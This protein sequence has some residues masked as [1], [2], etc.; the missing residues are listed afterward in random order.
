MVGGI[1]WAFLTPHTSTCRALDSFGEFLSEIGRIPLL[2]PA[3]E[4]HLGTICQAWQQHPDGPADCP[5][6][7]RRRGL[8]A[9]ERMT[10]ANLRLV[11]CIAR[12][13][14]RLAE[15]RGFTLAD[16]CQ[17]GA[18]GLARGVEKF[19]PAKGYKLSTYA[20]W[21]IRQGIGRALETGGLI[22]LP[23]GLR[24][25]AAK[26]AEALRDL[27]PEATPEAVAA[28]VGEP[29]SRCALAMAAREVARLTSL[30][31]KARSDNDDGSSVIE[32]LADP[33]NR[34]CTD[35]L[36]LAEAV[37]RLGV[38]PGDLDLMEESLTSTV[39][40][41]AKAQGVTRTTMSAR[42][43]AARSRL[44]TIAGPDARALLLEAA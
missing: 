14:T 42:L 34:P 40:A 27:G 21:W 36:E 1:A 32:L 12:R 23:T 16:L 31:G 7:I 38:L 11:V 39:T 20:Y 17:E 6:D 41:L 9:R 25:I 24:R 22:R 28:V 13:S 5:A 30:D 35:S 37:A 8:R 10:K 43:K 33:S 18:I 2:T 15:D 3:E 19:D 44:A 26:T 29:P 4:L